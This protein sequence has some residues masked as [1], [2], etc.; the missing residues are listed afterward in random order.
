VLSNH[1]DSIMPVQVTN[2]RYECTWFPLAAGLLLLAAGYRALADDEAYIMTPPG[3]QQPG[4]PKTATGANTAQLQITVRDHKTGMSTPCRLNVIGPDGHFYQPAIDRLSSYSLTGQWPQA[5]KGNR[6]GKAPIHYLGRFFYTTGAAKLTVPA[7]KVRLE[8]W[9]GIEYRPVAQIVDL[10][11]GQSRSIILELE[12]TAPMSTVGYHSGD[13]HL[14]FPRKT[15]S[16]D[17]VIFD[18]LEAEDISFASMLA[19]NE[20]AGPYAGDMETMDAPQLFGLGK[21]SVRHRG[22]TWIASGQEYRSTTYGHLNIYLDEHLILKGTKANAN[23]WPLYGQLGRETIRRGGFAFYAH[24]GYGQ[25]ISADFVQR[26]INAVELL[27]FGVYRGIELGG[28]YDILNIGY[29]FPCLGSSDYPACRTLGDCRTYVYLQDNVGFAEWLKSATEGR[30]FVTTGPLLL[31]DVDGRQPGGTIR[32][33]R[34]DSHQVRVRI[35]VTG[36]VAVI[37]FVQLIVNGKVVH[38]QAVP[39]G[40]GL[41]S[42]IELDRLLEL[43]RSSWIAARAFGQAPSGSPDAEAHTNPVYVDLDDKAPYN[44][45]SLDRL[46]ARLDQQMAIHRKRDF[47]EKARVLDDF[48]K[49]RD[50]LLRIRQ[51]GGLPASGV[52]DDWINEPTSVTIDASRRTHNDEELVRF[53]QPSP[54]KAPAEAQQT[55]ETVDGFQMELVAAEPLLQSPVAAA[56]D[57]D[58][59]LYVAEM[60][61]YPYKPKPGNKPLGTIRLLRDRNGDGR[62]DESHV[63]AD[64]LLWSAGIAPWKGG[65][66]VTAPP[67]IW[68]L[69]DTDHDGKADVRKKVYTGFGTQNQQAMVNN[70]TWGLDHKIYGAAAG[71]GGTIHPIDAP[72]TPGVSVEHNNFRFDPMSGVFEPISGSDQ[73]GNTFHDWGNRFTCDESH[74]L[75]QPVLPRSALARN[76]FLAVPSAVQDIAG[77]SVPIFRISPIERWRQIRS[78]RRIA[79]GT[80]SAETAGASHHVVDAGAGATVYR[81]ST[82]PAEYYGNVFIGNAQNNLIHRRI[83]VPDGPTFQAIRGPREQR[84][85]F[86]RSSDNWFRPVNFVNAPDGTLYVLDMSRAVIEAIHIPLDVVKHLDLKR[87]RDQ[88]RIYRIAPP[89]FHFAPPPHLSLAPMVDLIAALLRPDAW[90]RD[91]A[92]RLIYERQDPAAIRPLRA[93]LNPARAPLPVSRVN[94][95]WSLEGMQALRDDDILVALS[96]PD[97]QVRSQ[98]VQLAARRLKHSLIL[99]EKVLALATDPDSR[100]RF[101]VALAMGES[102]GPRVEHAL[103]QIARRDARDPWICSAVLSSCTTTAGGLLIDLWNDP[104]ARA[105]D[106]ADATARTAMLGQLAEIVGACNRTEQI[107]G[108]LDQLAKGS[109]DGKRRELRNQL[110]LKIALGLRR[111]GG[112]LP[113]APASKKEGVR[114]VVHLIQD[115]RKRALDGKTTESARVEAIDHLSTLDAAGSSL[116][117]WELL[118]PRQ[119]LTIQIAAVRA[120]A[121]SQSADMADRLLPRLRGFEP[122]VRT[123]AVRTLLTHAN[124]TKALLQAMNRDNSETGITP[125]LIESADRTPLLKH[126]DT[127]IARLAKRLF[128]KSTSPS[129]SRLVVDYLEAL[130]LKAEPNRGAKVFK[131]E[132]KTCHRVGD[133]GFDLGPD[134]TGSPSGDPTALLSNILDPNRS[135]IPNYV[136]YLVVDQKGRTYSG[137]IVAETATSLTLRRGEGVED[138]ILRAHIAEIMSTGLSL[139]P[140]G[141]EKTISK[142]EMAAPVA[143]LRAA[144]RGADAGDTAA[145]DPSHPLDIGTLPGLIEPDR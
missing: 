75:S 41:G 15:E 1:R 84:T 138:T 99:V 8:A 20:S 64:G 40:K 42:W 90:Y 23:N 65:V 66:F 48:Q 125:A 134:L 39:S 140:E 45:D 4:L 92:H 57:A 131:R 54:A 7:G 69:K 105:V 112:Q 28:W 109:G 26:N 93:L 127:E 126:R 47:A 88:G 63:F 100:V 60:R 86:I 106:T 9:K 117:L 76:P 68:Y 137:V 24:G 83:L 6:K 53:L 70:L 95:L 102:I 130:Q 33:P 89:G 62:F 116:V 58:G 37:Q 119:P 79:H 55:F 103:L 120:L 43:N 17:Q 67:D 12:R 25:A 142:P 145:F 136:Q 27:Q 115:A 61:D 82:W 121:E 98:A 96:D 122:Q 108:V 59:A 81:G 2:G 123:T 132:C 87:G 139:M 78:S 46:V 35:R 133:Q 31:L 80:R 107:D 19:Y 11:A 91:T 94:A 104:N 18:L 30:S 51:D 22:E 32:K 49:S 111:S 129:R 29:H 10:G 118:D 144:H 77:S 101:Q 36:E 128:E 135:I 85:E 124:W 34:A 3:F 74:P 73:F 50:I 97:P 38:E 72:Q 71:N 113:S 143:F 13:M 110:V 16:D 44:R 14:H 114:L 56:F 52:P 5:G 141:F 21:A